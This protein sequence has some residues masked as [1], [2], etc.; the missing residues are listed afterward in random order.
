MP[1]VSIIIPVYNVEKYLRNC[2]D[3]VIK[4]TLKDIE[5]I[6]V[7]DESPDNCGTILDEYAL[8]DNRIKV[9]HQKNKGVAVAR[10]KGLDIALGDYIGFLDSDD[11]LD[12]DFY[13]KLYN[14]A[15][16]NKLDIVKGGVLNTNYNNQIHI[17]QLNNL[18]QTNGKYCFTYEWW[19]AIYRADLIK[20]NQIRFP[21]ECSNGEDSVFLTKL[22]LK[23]KSLELCNDTFYHYI[24]RKDS[25]DT[26]LLNSKKIK[27]VVIAK[28]YIMDE[29]NKSSMQNEEY[30]QL[31]YEHY[32]RLFVS[33]FRTNDENSKILIINQIIDLFH[34]CRNQQY[35][36]NNIPYKWIIP[37]IKNKQYNELVNILVKYTKEKQLIYPPQSFIK[38]IFSITH[39]NNSR[40]VITILGIKI[41][42]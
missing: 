20:N 21:E 42:V 3:S 25:L 11:M 23:C 17:S 6:C 41:K 15:K 37:Y 33:L 18:I 19:S 30:S 26:P 5:I 40:K 13:E 12:V 39:L 10:N 4:Q 28:N 22:L 29:L 14:K 31:Y 16:K 2:L 36:E 1:K 32:S 8:K 38:K 35:I 27:S 34:I 7:D 9:I 24:R